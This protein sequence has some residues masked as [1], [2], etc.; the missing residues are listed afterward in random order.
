VSTP[1]VSTPPVPTPPVPTGAGDSTT[2]LAH[3]P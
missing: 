3:R 2:G 1:P